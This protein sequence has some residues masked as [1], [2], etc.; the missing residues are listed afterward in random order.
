MEECIGGVI[1]ISDEFFLIFGGV[2][3][4]GAAEDEDFEFVDG[5]S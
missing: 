4:P 3:G 1:D 2:F 5:M